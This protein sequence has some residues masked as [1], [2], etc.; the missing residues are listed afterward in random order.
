MIA[1]SLL[2]LALA[3]CVGAIASQRER[4]GLGWFV[5][6]LLASPVVAGLVL[7]AIGNGS[8][9]K[10]C[11]A[12]RE[13]VRM[14]ALRCRHCGEDLNSVAAR[15][16]AYDAQYARRDKRIALTVVGALA[17]AACWA[18]IAN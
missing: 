13:L 17:L 3:A 8:P 5:I 18:V 7:L 12:C 1:W 9:T 14:D 10:R 4:S 16:L 6:A 15:Q 2:W 11:P